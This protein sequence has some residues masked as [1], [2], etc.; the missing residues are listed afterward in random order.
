MVGHAVNRRIPGK[1]R[2]IVGSI[3][4]SAIRR[5]GCLTHSLTC[6]SLGPFRQTQARSSAILVNKLNSGSLEGS[7]YD[8]Q[9]SPARLSQPRFEL[10]HSYHPD[11][12]RLRKVVLTP[13]KETTR[14]SA[15]GCRNHSSNMAKSHVSCK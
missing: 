10:M 9:S 14:C 7:P 8:I 11:T 3:E 13:V 4:A 6:P 1:R 5:P 12:G 2:L 15:L